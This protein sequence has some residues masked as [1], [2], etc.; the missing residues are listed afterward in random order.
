MN[1]FVN[2]GTLFPPFL[3]SWYHACFVQKIAFIRKKIHKKLLPPELLFLA[4]ICTN[5]LSA[6][7][8]PQ[9]PPRK[10][11]SLPQTP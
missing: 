8:S 10:L 11:T 9:T 5:C 4:Q 3:F 6:G 2:S 7:A 1:E